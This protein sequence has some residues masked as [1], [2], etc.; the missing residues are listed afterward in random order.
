MKRG[1]RSGWNKYNAVRVK[2]GDI[3]FHSKGEAYRYTLLMKQ[4]DSGDISNLRVHPRY[5]IIIEGKR[6]CVYEADFEYV[7]QTPPFPIIVE[8]V[9]SLPTRTRLYQLKKKLIMATSGI[10]ITEVIVKQPK[11]WLTEEKKDEL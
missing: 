1:K 5:P 10:L 9:K 6:I 4:Q 2:I 8:D 11:N 3:T 7:L